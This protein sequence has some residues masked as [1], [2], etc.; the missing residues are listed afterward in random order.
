MIVPYGAASQLRAHFDDA[1]SRRGV[2]ARLPDHDEMQVWRRALR[3]GDL[4]VDVGANVGLYSLIAAEVGAEVLAFE[5]AM[6]ARKQLA[7]NL[8]LNGVVAEVIPSAVAEKPGT[9]TLSGRDSQR[10]HVG[11]TDA[12]DGVVVDVRTLDEVLGDRSAAGVK[13]D[14][15]GAERRVREGGS[16][17]LHE[18]RLGL[19]QLEWNDT[20]QKHFGETR[21][22]VAEL[23]RAA[24]YELCRPSGAGTL[25]AD[26]N[27]DLGRDVFARLR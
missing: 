25:H 19:I 26:P 11:A 24:G 7:D 27:P 1:G 4:F 2:Y 9:M 12:D 10:L 16:R 21:E 5:P 18:G 15:E 13:I 23:L 8:A 14:V 6:Y 17:A 20:S 3:P 22:P